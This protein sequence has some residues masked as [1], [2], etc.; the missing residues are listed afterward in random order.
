MRPDVPICVRHSAAK[1][2]FC[3]RVR[4]RRP[5]A[6]RQFWR[7]SS[8][9]Q[10]PLEVAG[11]D[12]GELSLRHH[13]WVAEARYDGLGAW[14][15]EWAGDYMRPFAGV[16]AAQVA[17]FVKPHGTVVDVGCGTGLHF[18]ALQA[19]NIHPIGVDLSFD[20]L[21]LAGKRSVV[22]RADAAALPLRDEA[23]DAA[24]AGFIHRDVDDF[25]GAVADVA[26]VLRPGGR[27]VSVGTHP[28][29]VAPFINRTKER[30][31]GKIEIRTG[32]GDT[33]RRFDSAAPSRLATT[34]GSR[35]LPIAAFLH[36]FLS[37]GLRIESLV[38]MDTRAQPWVAEP[39]D[40]TIL[41]WNILVVATKS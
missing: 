6:D 17:E 3:A 28:C 30:D 18:S 8:G 27:F 38:E 35:N 41:P 25:A 15:E 32:Y 16:L 5:G 37:A 22:V 2:L 13:G 19:Q 40:Q 29:F 14:Y 12:A 10:A 20:Q 11:S 26:R 33:E 24:V 36:T 4:A 23:I 7:A 39:D 1:P 21:R 9:R 31:I 34:V